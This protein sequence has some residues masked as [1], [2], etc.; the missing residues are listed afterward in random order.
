MRTSGLPYDIQIPEPCHADWQQMPVVSSA[1]RHCGSCARQVHDLSRLSAREI[2]RLVESTGGSFCGRV[3]HRADGSMLLREEAART[4]LLPGAGFVLAA[5]LATAGIATSADAQNS[6]NRGTAAGASAAGGPQ[7][8][9]LGQIT[10]IA[11]TRS[12]STHTEPVLGGM[13]RPMQLRTS[14]EGQLHAPGGAVGRYGLVLLTDAKGREYRAVISDQGH[15]SVQLPPGKY[16]ATA[17]ID[18][19]GGNSWWG[20]EAITVQ[21]GKQSRDFHPSEPVIHTAGAPVMV[22][23]PS[24]RKKK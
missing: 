19:P 15:Y 24:A 14:L 1:A 8:A 11:E 7:K 22:P 18:V 13:I 12:D 10:P 9:S 6:S 3:T 5:A 17:S 2:R 23:P 20:R 16:I 21:E 4:S